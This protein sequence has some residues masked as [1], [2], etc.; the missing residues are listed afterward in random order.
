MQYSSMDC[1]QIRGEMLRV[2]GQVRIL[3]GK[4][5]RKHKNDQIAMGVGLVI[6][7]PALFFLIG[8]DKREELAEMKGQYDALGAAGQQLKC[9]TTAEVRRGVR[10]SEAAPTT[11]A[12][13]VPVQ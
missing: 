8:G 1:D 12:W 3:T 11:E 10:T 9:G 13:T 2:S 6:A 5:L 7:W 4:Q